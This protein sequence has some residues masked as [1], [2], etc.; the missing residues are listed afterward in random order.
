MSE[1]IPELDM[2]ELQKYQTWARTELISLLGKF[3]QDPAFGPGADIA[4]L[5]LCLFSVIIQCYEGVWERRVIDKSQFTPESLGKALCDLVTDT[6]EAIRG[7]KE[8][9]P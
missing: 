6:L 2:A 3:G 7:T 5:L 1:E 9:Q 4:I 8:R